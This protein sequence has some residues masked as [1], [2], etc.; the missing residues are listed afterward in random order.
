MCGV[1]NGQP[2][3]APTSCRALLRRPSRSPQGT[4]V[5]PISRLLTGIQALAAQVGEVGTRAT[6]ATSPARWLISPM[7]HRSSSSWSIGPQGLGLLR[8][9]DRPEGISPYESKEFATCG[10]RGR[11]AL[12]RLGATL[13]RPTESVFSPLPLGRCSFE[14]SAGSERMGVAVMV[15]DGEVI[16]RG[17]LFLPAIP[18]QVEPDPTGRRVW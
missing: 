1:Q 6:P 5:L 8:Q 7:R 15:G 11:S 3:Q 10:I 17:G 18:T 9:P 13:G 16:A 14:S 12:H 4:G 2:L